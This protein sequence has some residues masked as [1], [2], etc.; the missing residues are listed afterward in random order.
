[1]TKCSDFSLVE[2]IRLTYGVAGDGADD[3]PVVDSFGECHVADYSV[4]FE[5]SFGF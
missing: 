5:L 4:G 3:L 2:T 1:M